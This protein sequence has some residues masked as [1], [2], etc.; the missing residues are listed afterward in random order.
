MRAQ[1]PLQPRWREVVDLEAARRAVAYEMYLYRTSQ[2][3]PSVLPYTGGLLDAWPATLVDAWA[4]LT[5]EHDVVNGAW[6]H[7]GFL[8]EKGNLWRLTEDG[9]Q[10]VVESAPKRRRP[11]G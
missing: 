11:H 4:V 7:D 3:L 6:R 1:V 9:P 2:A 8:V 5:R 10:A